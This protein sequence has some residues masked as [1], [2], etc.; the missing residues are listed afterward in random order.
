MCSQMSE[1]DI[2]E[3][4]TKQR[5]MQMQRKILG[6]KLAELIKEAREPPNG[7]RVS[8]RRALLSRIHQL[9]SQ[10]DQLERLELSFERISN[11]KQT[12]RMVEEIK[13][14]FGGAG[15][16]PT[17]DG[18][19]ELEDSIAESNDA[20]KEIEEAFSDP[21]KNHGGEMSEEDFMKEIN[22]LYGTDSPQPPN[23]PGEG[24]EP[25]IPDFP[26]AGSRPIRDKSK[27]LQTTAS[28]SSNPRILEQAE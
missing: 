15:N 14:A 20:I 11:I 1:A 16:L 4:E 24:Q 28:P 3:A 5:H 18:I 6:Q 27:E 2:N 21:W 23:Y 17:A 19:Y 25:P 7:V 10:M 13:N 26:E 22:S 8:S 9:R 12:A